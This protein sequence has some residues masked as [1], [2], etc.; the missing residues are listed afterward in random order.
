ML[1]PAWP[2][3]MRRSH[4]ASEEG[5]VP[6]AAG[7]SRVALLPSWW[8]DSQLSVLTRS[9]HCPCVTMFGLMPLPSG[10]VPGNSLGAG[11]LAN[12]YQ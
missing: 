12:E 7:I 6:R 4:A 5:K 1:G 3:W 10:P 11:T 9:T 2:D 8:H